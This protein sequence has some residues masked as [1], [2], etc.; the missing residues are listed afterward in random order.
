MAEADTNLVPK[1]TERLIERRLHY[2]TT[3]ADQGN[4]LAECPGEVLLFKTMCG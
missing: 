4:K 1:A 2:I 3:A